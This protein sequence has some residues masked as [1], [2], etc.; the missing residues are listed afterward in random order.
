VRLVE[1]CW[2]K[3]REGRVERGGKRSCFGYLVRGRQLDLQQCSLVSPHCC[4]LCLSLHAISS[5][6]HQQN[7]RR[8]S[9]QA[10]AKPAFTSLAVEKEG[11]PARRQR[12]EPTSSRVRY[13]HRQ[14]C[15]PHQQQQHQHL[16]NHESHN[17][18]L[19]SRGNMEMGSARGIRRHVRYLQSQ[20]RRHM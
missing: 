14:V 3:E 9:S 10:Q 7:M 1:E 2:W 18:L 16:S 8:E 17:Q 4:A 19:P 11:L 20:L 15:I 5:R 12:D 6:L 13:K